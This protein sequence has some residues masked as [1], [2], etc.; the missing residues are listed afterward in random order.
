VV[1]ADDPIP[2]VTCPGCKKPMQLRLL[3]PASGI[4]ETATY[5]CEQ[6]GTETKREF[7]RD[8]KR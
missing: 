5:H 8:K 6:C 1:K 7:V 2:I 4:L 3:Q